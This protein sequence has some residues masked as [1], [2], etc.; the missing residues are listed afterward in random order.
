MDTNI[1]TWTELLQQF[2]PIFT[3]PGADIFVRLIT[4]WIPVSDLGP[5]HVAFSRKNREKKGLGVVSDDPKMSAG[6]MIRRYDERWR[7]EV[8]FKDGKQLPGLGQYQNVSMEAAV[9]HL[10]LVCF[11]YALLTH[12]A[13]A[14]EGAKAKHQSAVRLSTADLQN[15]ARRIVWEDLSEHLKQLSSGTQVVKELERLLIAT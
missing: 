15:E 10:H 6:Q 5:L 11:A 12:I 1:S 13:I 4:G 8:F 14:G 2:F 9:T 7:I 3:A